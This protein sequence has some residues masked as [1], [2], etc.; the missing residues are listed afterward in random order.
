MTQL[1]LIR[2]GETGWNVQGRYQG[3]A[4]PPLPNPGGKHHPN[5]AT[6]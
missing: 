2:H 1:V 5:T 3:Q 4:D 6:P